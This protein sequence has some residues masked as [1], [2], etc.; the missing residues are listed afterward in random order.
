MV[1]RGAIAS[2]GKEF[3]RILEV[4]LVKWREIGGL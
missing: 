4:G 3:R 2:T 1:L